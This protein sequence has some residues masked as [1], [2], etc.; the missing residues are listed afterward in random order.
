MA[1][2]IDFR[3]KN[4]LL[5]T[6]TATVEGNTQAV[7]TTTGALQ[8]AGGAGIGKDLHVGGDIYSQNDLVLTTATLNAYGV[9]AIVAGTDTAVSTESGVVVVWGTA[10]L[11]TVTSRGGDTPS[12][13][14]IFNT[15]EA[16]STI[17]G[18]L[19]VSGGVGIAGSLYVGGEIIADSLVGVI[20]TSSALAG[21]TPGQIP[22]QVE[23]DETGFTG[24]G[25]A[26]EVL[27]S[28]GVAG[29]I[30]QNTLTLASTLD[31]T[32]T[33]TGAFRTLGGAGIARSVFV[34]Q[35]LNV[36]SDAIITGDIG[37]NGGDF[38]TNQ[39]TFNLLNTTATTINF[40]GV[41]TNLT[42]GATTGDTTVRNNTTI[43]SITAATST[44]TGALVVR[45]GVGINRDAW[46]G[47]RLNVGSDAIIGG[48][49]AVNGGDIIT[50][51]STFNLVNTTATTVNIAGAATAI[52]IGAA[53]GVTTIRNLTTLTNLTQS[54]S[55][56]TGALQV[57]GGV[58]I[59][60]DLYVGGTFYGNI[61]GNI[62]GIITT[63]SN[64]AA[65]QAGEIPYQTGNGITS[66][67]GTST[68]G[69]I[70]TSNGS[71][72]P[73]WNNTLNLTGT[74]VATS[75]QTG[76]LIVA[77]GVG[78][79]E[80][81]W[82]GNT[83]SVLSTLASTS[84]IRSNALYVAGGVGIA[85]SLFVQGPTVFQ[86]D[87]IFSGTSTYVFS[88]QTVYTDNL[89]NLHAPAGSTGTNHTWAVD[90]G[91]DIGLV[92]H[93]YTGTDKDAFLGLDSET[94]Y[95]EWFDNGTE[96]LSSGKFTGT[97][98]GIFK[99]GGIILAHTTA[100][101][102]PTT[103]ALTVAGGAG[104]GGNVNI[105]GD[106]RVDGGDI[107]AGAATFN[108]IN[109]TAT[110]IN[111]GGAGTS[112]TIGAT[113]GATTVRNDLT[114]TSITE[115]TSTATGALQVRGGVGI[116]RSAWIGQ[117]LNVGSDA[118]IT[119]DLSVNGGDIITNQTTFNLINTT[120]T[121]VNI[122]G[123]ATALTLGATTGATT[124]RNATTITSITGSSSTATGALV[125][126]GGAGIAENLYVGSNTVITGD[127]AVNG[128]DLNTTAAT[129]NLVNA[130]ATTVNLAGA[131]TNI[132]IG[133]T[134]G[135]TTIRNATTITATT[136][137]VST[138]TG[139]LTVAG[140][141]G[142]QGDLRVG[143][144]IYGSVD[145]SVNTATNLA[146]GAAG[147]I[148]YQTGA[149]ATGFIS[150]GTAGTIFVSNGNSAPSWNSTLTLASI[151]NASS[152]ATGA[153]VVRGG[154]GIN[155]NLYVGGTTNLIGATTVE[156]VTE[157][158]STATGAL[159][160]RGGAGINRNLYVGQGLEV[161]ASATV[162]G[163]VAV[164]GGDLT[165]NQ[166]TFNLLNGTVTTANVLGAGTNITI[167]ATTG[168]TTIR[169]ATTV[170]SISGAS[171]TATGALQVRGGVGVNENIFVGGVASI[172][173]LT[174][175]TNIT[176]S[177]S[178][179]TGALQVR[180]GVGINRSLYV[181]GTANIA[182]VTTITNAT[183]ATTT[184][185][186]ALQV[187]GG[188]GVGGSVY[189]GDSLSVA[190][191]A[192]IDAIRVGVSANTEIDT[193]SGNLTI[194]SAGG[195]V[196]IDDN[197]SVSGGAVITGDVAVNGGDITTNQAT[198][199][200]L[201][202]TVTTANILG[203]AT[204][205]NLGADSGVLTVRNRTTVTDI[206]NATSTATGAL[207]VRGGV[208][209]NRDLHVGG[210]IY[211]TFSG[212]IT[213][214][215]TT[216]TDA[217]NVLTTA[218]STNASFFVTFVDS[219]NT[220]TAAYERVFTDAGLSYNPSTNNLSLGNDMTVGGDLT[221]NG[222]DINTTAAS[223]NL[224]NENVT[225]ANVLG[226]ATNITLGANSGVLTVR[227][228]T[229]VTDITNASSTATGAL[230]V[231]G[232]LGVNRDTYL[233]GL[234]NIGGVTTVN[235]ITAASSTATGAL[236]VRGGTGIGG[237]L[238]VG[239]LASIA[240]DATVG[241][242]L[243]VNGGD[244]TSSQATFNLL[245]A[246]VTTANVLGAGTNIT[247]GATTG[248]TTI[249]NN[250]TITSITAASSTATG[251]LV[252]RGG[253]GING[254]LYVGGN[255]VGTVTTSGSTNE[256][257]TVEATT[258]TNYYI[259]F[260]Q[261][262]NT[263]RASEQI[264]TDTGIKYN[265][266]TD[267]L[268][269]DGDLA[270]NGGDI[271]S[272][273]ATFNL[274]NATVTTANVLGAGTNITIGATTG[275][276]TVRNNTT[277]TSITAATSTATGALQVRGGAGI[278]GNLYVGG[279][280]HGT[281]NSATNLAGGSAMSIVYQSA[282]N[283]TAFLAAGSAGFILS[284]NGTGAAPTWI[285]P[286]G[287]SAGSALTATNANN[288][289]TLQRGTTA[290]H[291]LTFVDSDNATAAYEA[292]YTDA[293]I[294]YNP[295]TNVLEVT[296]NTTIGGDLAV[297]GGDI[298]SNQSTFNLLNGT[299]T[300]ANVLGAGTNIT[301][302]AA[303][304]A[305][306]IQN[307]VTATSTANATSTATGALRVTGGVGIGR[308]LWVGGTVYG[309]ITTSSVATTSTYANE[310]RTVATATAAAFYPTFVNSN[311][312]TEGY[313]ALY[314][315]AGIS[316][317]PSSN[318][319]TISG[320]FNVNG[321]DIITSAAAFNLINTN[322]T[323]VNIAG[324]ATALTLGATSGS[325][326]IRNNVTVAGNLTVQGATTIVDSTVTN[327]TDPILTL[328]GLANNANPTSDDA[329]DRGIA[330]KWYDTAARFGFFGFDRSTGH[331]TYVPQATITNEVISGTKGAL[332]ANLAGGAAM[333]LVY[334]SAANTTAFLAAGT[335]GYFLRTNGTG[336]AP[337][338]VDIGSIGAGSATTAS[339]A[340]N[341]LTQSTA[342]SANFYLTFVNSDNAVPA[343]E[344]LYSDAG[345]AY[346]PS[347]NNLTLGGD[348]DVQGGDLT[349]NQTTFN[350]VNTNASTVNFAGAS[351]ALTIG[352][353]AAG[354]VQI[355]NNT[356]ATSTA[357]GALRVNGGVGVGGDLYAANIYSN[358][359][360][361]IP[362]NIQE[363][364]ATGGQTTFT[365]TGG[366]V[367]GTVQ[368]FANGIALGSS[369]FV[370]SNGT[371]VVVTYARKAGDIIRVVSG[372]TSS[373]ANNIEAF[374][375]AMSVA[376]G[377]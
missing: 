344:R 312:G 80:S 46:I 201:N 326:T 89:L 302:G 103:G 128:G 364:T 284:T 363:F 281:V 293:G 306:T 65:G 66:F 316:Y 238:Y 134:T 104:F 249:R 22:F 208:G 296:G 294:T 93:Y 122:A 57:R 41:A 286:T 200:F 118:I 271:T 181:G 167:G 223:F 72:A 117:R 105:S 90:D 85:G 171:S 16:M 323:T 91:K 133:A 140:G 353:N 349:T 44:A 54:V 266:S 14:R 261:D 32:S 40:A 214:T 342:T 113:T 366:Y 34:G 135:A 297:N 237:A 190:V 62:T 199:N 309:T 10:T 38:I 184:A 111:F 102:S 59:G 269:L 2:I 96:D 291:Y 358:G 97:S 33:L 175:V 36:G 301:I 205:I 142:I 215:A 49:V 310:V 369:D 158:S 206:T 172:A 119:G 243:A 160:V 30:F 154:V 280:V 257:F 100:S 220:G 362:L 150:N 337:T 26:G 222:G 256:V 332:D 50:N 365:V 347:T 275:A 250:T 123:A 108:L 336:S 290:V 370:A 141:V 317:N 139:A 282:A 71:N 367:V 217:V 116:N 355:R 241:G 84:S 325:T 185:T 311:N 127:L 106:L 374:S 305:T 189:I 268:T 162:A 146:G 352:A 48:D 264:N 375:V 346:N 339:N 219:N 373:A 345:I 7:S 121:T 307:Q 92:F 3:V 109:T 82:V 174:T 234:L 137:T 225:S 322:A 94:K 299:V 47:Q 231:R 228:A 292:L 263:T 330:F 321:G 204:T 224:L 112:V 77:G 246:T 1:D 254:N 87:V 145:A 31:A 178:T 73:T 86:N 252:V 226:A 351:T 13:I 136:P 303:T 357:T 8:V 74:T 319:L 318:D 239:G 138:A 338:W 242:D 274:L 193:V 232:G 186:G 148:P 295:G 6:T 188:V 195:T 260:V 207:V 20:T 107:F 159:V 359:T 194:D 168:A 360:R 354:Y 61:V 52:T 340:D 170:S 21:G 37:V 197:L 165:S 191:G 79:G 53:T 69:R 262:N 163:D 114:V 64:I 247:L 129:F 244:I 335:S 333:S 350:L 304:G 29:P 324:A 258:N 229:T 348:L 202:S 272:T 144:I 287:V 376:L 110:T 5:V 83:A 98:Y 155:R 126:R 314:T 143:G 124:I 245:N 42:I 101:N 192:T 183:A 27:V 149:G 115:A 125:V 68:A 248:V 377:I 198:F 169:N 327:V 328:G 372:G 315:D 120:A 130:N 70:L 152:T 298:T 265:P 273:A 285:S 60:G 209:V 251:A 343:Y 132:T 156:S 55:S 177:T 212:S 19:Q 210:V 179:A 233:G 78:I 43:T 308:D 58:G 341:V 356:N 99:T 88:T 289:A 131:G 56:T 4:G 17:T 361:V 196:T 276:T 255:I 240:G 11:E 15:S 236:Q 25:A 153:L 216:A 39:T 213:G 75:T 329:K 95:L 182:G 313:E 157:S 164:N 18:A 320:D 253:V 235:N 45:G 278:G 211:G 51:Q 288:I 270:V 151:D 277:V 9:S 176:E 24:P 283:T 161:G 218:T 300:T 180:G 279:T 331:L 368:V 267:T 12:A 187:L 227:N 230:V 63:A 259:T 334:Q 221:V 35:R 147:N 76:A 28:R 173:G 166:T 23:T 203:A 371:T 67:I 81:L